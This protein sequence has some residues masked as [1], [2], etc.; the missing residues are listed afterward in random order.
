MID[1]PQMAVYQGFGFSEKFGKLLHN[2]N[3]KTE[4]QIKDFLDFSPSRLHDPFFLKG[5][6]QAVDRINLAITKREQILI[7]GD[8]DCDGIC[9]TAILY[10]YFLTRRARVKYFLPNRDADGYGLTVELIDTLAKRFMPKLIITVDCGISCPKEVA[11]AQ[12]LGIDVIVTDHHSIPEV[13]PNCICVN[14]KLPDQ[15]YPFDGLCGAGVALKLVQAL[16]NAQ[17]AM[18]YIDICALATVADIVPLRDENRIIVGIGLKMLN[19]GSNRAV[20]ALSKSCNVYG[21][22]RASDISYKLGPKINASGRMGVAKRGIDLLLEKDEHRVNEIIKSLDDLNNERRKLCHDITVHAERI[23]DE[24]QLDKNNIIIVF[25]E[26]W[27][28]GVLGIVSARLVDKYGKPTM[29]LSKS[30][31]VWKGSARSIGDFN[32]VGTLEQFSDMLVTFGGHYM[33]AGLSVAPE[34]FTDF[35]EKFTAHANAQTLST[36]DQNA[37]ELELKLDEITHSFILELEKLE[38]TGCENPAPLFMTQIQGTKAAALPNFPRHL[39]FSVPFQPLSFMYFDG[40]TNLEL[41]QS[42]LPKNVLF[43]FQKMDTPPKGITQKTQ[44]KAIVKSLEIADGECDKT[45]AFALFGALMGSLPDEFITIHSSLIT[46]LRVDR[47]TFVEYYKLIWSAKG[48]R[49]VGVYDLFEKLKADK[50]EIELYQFVFCCAVFMDLQI[51][52]FDGGVVRVN[53]KIKTELEKSNVYNKIK[54]E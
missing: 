54:G 37:P 30:E 36:A 31:N 38:P 26:A 15:E 12:S 8:Y 43:E 32:M 44:I 4:Q 18:K 52:K 13:M 22:L 9:A 48:K 41:L 35:I 42:D 21:S 46:N 53:E 34:K 27:E 7:I 39:R 51:L 25:D 23:V 24:Q 6:A 16:S 50:K 2:R 5:M 49:A 3:I 33:A 17:T 28:G 40:A 20:T 11:H 1:T 45:K 14:P 29:V 19:E 10:K 47:E